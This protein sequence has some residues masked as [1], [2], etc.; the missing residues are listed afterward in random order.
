M[1]KNK[2]LMGNYISNIIKGLDIKI[3][4]KNCR[5]KEENE[6]FDLNMLILNNSFI[7][8]RKTTDE[9]F[10]YQEQEIQFDSIFQNISN[11]SMKEE[12][13]LFNDTI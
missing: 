11:I 5:T 8:K 3:G 9:E 1:E 10:E 6:Q 12:D 13:S 7:K 4:I 2:D